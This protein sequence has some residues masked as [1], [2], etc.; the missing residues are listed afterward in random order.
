MTYPVHTTHRG[1]SENCVREARTPYCAFDP[2]AVSAFGARDKRRLLANAGIV[3]NRKKVESS[4]QNVGRPGW[5]LPV[6]TRPN[7][8]RH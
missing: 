8:T 1:P 3:R 4:I 6:P 2:V 5:P 7:Q